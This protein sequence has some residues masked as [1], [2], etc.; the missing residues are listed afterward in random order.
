[1]INVIVTMVIKEGKL[2]EFIAECAKVRPLVLEE[3][4]CIAYDYMT[5]MP[6]A[7]TRQEPVNAHRVTLIERWE[8]LE[9]I[10]VHSQAKHM[11][12]FVAKV[13][14]LRESVVIRVGKPAF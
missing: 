4:G 6:T 9:D 3:K 11:V 1:M 5:E 10:D 8:S 12:E 13:K 2:N 7:M 14:D